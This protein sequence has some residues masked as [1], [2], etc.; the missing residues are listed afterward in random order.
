MFLTDPFPNALR[1]GSHL[2]SLF[3]SVKLERKDEI[4]ISLWMT[5]GAILAPAL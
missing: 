2:P 4:K 5:S 1:L 3:Q